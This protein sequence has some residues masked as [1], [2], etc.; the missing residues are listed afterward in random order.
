MS[1]SEKQLN[2]SYDLRHGGPWDRGSAD[3]YYG[4]DFEPHYFVGATHTSI[5]ISQ[6]DMSIAEIVA[7]EAGYEWNEKHGEKKAW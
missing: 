3:S 4:R 2:A 1:I 6:K 5:R 7:Y